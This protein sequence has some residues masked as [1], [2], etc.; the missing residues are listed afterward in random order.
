MLLVQRDD[1]FENAPVDN[2]LSL[3]VVS[4]WPSLALYRAVSRFFGSTRTCDRLGLSRDLHRLIVAGVV[5]PLACCNAGVVV[6]VVFKPLLL[7]TVV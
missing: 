6:V 7:S 4:R 2:F 5:L 3:F 1:G